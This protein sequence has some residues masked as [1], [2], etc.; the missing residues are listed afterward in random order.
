MT[1]SKAQVWGV[2]LAM[3]LVALL[4]LPSK[5]GYFAS[6]NE[7]SLASMSIWY[8]IR[9]IPSFAVIYIY[10]MKSDELL[11]ALVLC[12]MCILALSCFFYIPVYI[13]VLYTGA[14]LSVGG[15]R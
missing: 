4:V 6:A 1:I 14:G 8:I 9:C 11:N 3:P 5:F 2:A 13:F 15:I 10:Y 12:G 7:F